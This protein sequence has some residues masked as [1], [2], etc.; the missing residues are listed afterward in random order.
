MRKLILLLPLLLVGQWL[1]AA[2][3]HTI[4]VTIGAG[5]TQVV[6]AG[7]VPFVREV[8]FQNNATHVMRVGDSTTTSSKGVVL[9]SGPGGG[10]LNIGPFTDAR[11]DLSTFFVNGTNTDVL[12]VSWVD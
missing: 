10:S 2:A 5:T 7:S 6:S 12:D 8:F 11:I 1:D 9:L 4:Q 3:M